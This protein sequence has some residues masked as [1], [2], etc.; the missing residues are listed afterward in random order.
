MVAVVKYSMVKR[1]VNESVKQSTEIKHNTLGLT[2]K[3]EDDIAEWYSQVILKSEMA[4]YAP[5]KGCMII[6]PLGYAIWENIQEY[7]NKKLKDFKVKNAYFPLF[8]PESFFQKEASHAAGFKPEVA[9][10]ANKYEGERLAIRPTSET[11]IYDAYAR[12]IRSHRD[13]PLRLNQWCNVVRWETEATKIFLRT[14]EFLWQEGHCAYAGLNE[15]E[16][17]TKQYIEFYQTLVQE[18]LAIPVILGEKTE[19]ERFAG[20]I[21]TYTI[22]AFMP[23]GKALQCGTS[24]NLGQNFGKAFN[25]QYRGEDEKQHYVWQNSWGLS[26]RLL[27][28]LV[29]LHADNKGLVLPPRIAP[30]KLL[31]VPILFDKTKEAVLKKAKKFEQLFSKAGISVELDGREEYSPGFKFNKGELRGI[32]L[33]IELGPKD[34]EKNQV[35]LVRRDTGEKTFVPENKLVKTIQ[36]Q[37]EQMQEALFLNA[38]KTLEQS[39]VVVK[40]SKNFQETIEARKIAKTSF[41][42]KPACEELIKEKTQGATSRCIDLHDKKLIMDKCIDCGEKAKYNVYFSKS[43]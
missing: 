21:K 15:C 3:K 2:I 20:A 6:R 42:G 34:L 17:E 7:F 24:H 37:L 31:I 39:I 18:L 27:G 32:P 9:W 13:L 14:R 29:L 36:E 23:D 4:E 11:I 35:V 41:C 26:T 8:I 5:V 19:K 1:S 40:D 25:I 43:Y 28:A 10:I 16:K 38:K 33:R 30:T 22:E 12:W